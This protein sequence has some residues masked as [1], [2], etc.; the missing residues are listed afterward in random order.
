[1]FRCN[2]C[3]YACFSFYREEKKNRRTMNISDL[4]ICW[5]DGKHHCLAS[6]YIYIYRR[7]VHCVTSIC[8]LCA[9]ENSS[10]SACI[11]FFSDCCECALASCSYVLNLALCVC[12][13]NDATTSSV[14]MLYVRVDSCDF[15]FFL[16]FD[17]IC[18]AWMKEKKGKLF[19]FPPPL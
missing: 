13:R 16:S 6:I 17:E 9:I 11:S 12:A 2:D 7:V 3:I 18:F 1:M 8:R 19:F 5:E 10:L 4:L 14:I 15:H